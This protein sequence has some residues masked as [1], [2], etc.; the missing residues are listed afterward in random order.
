MT[1]PELKTLNDKVM[2]ILAKYPVTRDSDN[3]LIKT[4][5]ELEK[6]DLL[7]I[8]T[9]EFF[10]FHRGKQIVES[11]TRAKR[12]IVAKNPLLAGTKTSNQRK[13]EEASYAGYYKNWF[14]H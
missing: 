12:N 10:T 6:P 9:V 4:Y 14:G 5:L 13:E 7:T 8:P 1:Y 11:V 2:Y 3:M